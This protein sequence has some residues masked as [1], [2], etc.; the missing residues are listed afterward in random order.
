VHAFEPRNTRQCTQGKL[1]KPD[2]DALQERFLIWRMVVDTV[3]VLV[4]GA[5]QATQV[6]AVTV[7]WPPRIYL[8]GCVSWE[9]SNSN[10]HFLKFPSVRGSSTTRE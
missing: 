3:L 4:R 2:E 6:E 1:L 8:D 9:Y 5:T 10:F 7:T